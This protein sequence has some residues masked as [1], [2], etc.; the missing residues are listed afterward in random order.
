MKAGGTYAIFATGF[1]PQTPQ[2]LTGNV[3]V[4]NAS[5]VRI[6]SSITA[7]PEPPPRQDGFRSSKDSLLA[8]SHFTCLPRGFTARAPGRTAR[9]WGW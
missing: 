7:V 3:F 6:S 8:K 4:A 2:T 9:C 5:N 1:N